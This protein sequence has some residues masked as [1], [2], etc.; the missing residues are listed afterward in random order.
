MRS[1]LLA[2]LLTLYP[3]FAAET[4]NVRDFGAKGDG[5]TSDT[6]A[7][8]HAIEAAEVKA[9]SQVRFPPGIYLSGTVELKSDEVLVIEPGATLMGTTNLAEYKMF[10]PPAGTPEAGFKAEWHRGLI[11]G[12]KVENVTITGGGEIDGHKVFDPKGEERMRGP[13]TIMIGHGRGIKVTQ[14]SIRDSANYAILLEDCSDSQ[15]R[16]VKITGGWDGIHFRGWPN[17]YCK[18]ITIADCQLFTGDDAIAGRYWENVVIADCTINSSC[19]GIRLIGPARKLMVNDC[20][21]IGPGK[22]PHRSSNR[23]NMLAAVALQPG[24][25][26]PTE[27]LLDDVHLSDLQIQN[28][29]TPFYFAL[30]GNNTVG[31]IEVNKVNATQIYRAPSSIESWNAHPF[32]NVIFRDVAIEY[33][34]GGKAEDANIAIKSPGVDAR[35]LP[36]WGFYARNVEKLTLENVQLRLSNSDLRPVARWENV[37]NLRTNNFVFPMVAG[38]ERPIET[39]RKEQ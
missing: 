26:D 17:S 30:K 3:C 11:L 20:Q 1:R 31:T 10:R 29:T 12:D 23:T 8:N 4:F 9:G 35:K 5:V 13:H 36:V 33:T 16:D 27:G 7:I 6:E 24:A 19:N 22:Y 37:Q 25:W 38:V 18:N 32:T 14:L 2:A 34:G 39:I 21:F 15:I 28:V